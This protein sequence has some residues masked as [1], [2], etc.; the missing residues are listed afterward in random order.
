MSKFAFFAPMVHLTAEI[1]KSTALILETPPCPVTTI[2][3]YKTNCYTKILPKNRILQQNGIVF[4]K[5]LPMLTHGREKRR[6]I[7]PPTPLL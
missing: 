4:C 5:K 6:T 7:P 2:I 3:H 1:Q